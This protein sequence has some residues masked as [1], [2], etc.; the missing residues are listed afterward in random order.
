MSTEPNQRLTDIEGLEVLIEVLQRDGHDVSDQRA[1][2]ETLRQK[3]T[4]D[5]A[6]R[7]RGLLAAD[8]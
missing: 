3:H 1:Q 6:A 2:L 7:F 8:R 4:K 5:I